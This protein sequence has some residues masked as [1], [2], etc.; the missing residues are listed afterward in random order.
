MVVRQL[1]ITPT[2][3]I[4]IQH[5]GR[6]QEMVWLPYDTILNILHALNHCVARICQ[7]QP[8]LLIVEI[9][10]RSDRQIDRQTRCLQYFA[11][12]RSPARGYNSYHITF[13]SYLA[14][15]STA[16]SERFLNTLNFFWK[17]FKSLSPVS[18][19]SVLF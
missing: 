14:Q 13:Y 17:T 10:E 18:I 9:W 7:R 12:S 16:L 4:C 15:P 2:V 3:K 1:L 5:L 6:V 8:R 11:L 19:C